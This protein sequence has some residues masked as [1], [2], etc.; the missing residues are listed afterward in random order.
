MYTSSM[1]KASDPQQELWRREAPRLLSDAD[2]ARIFGVTPG[3]IPKLR[4][5]GWLPRR[6]KV[7]SGKAGGKGVQ[8][9]SFLDAVAAEVARISSAEF[10]I[11]PRDLRRMVSVITGGDED[12]V[13]AS[14]VIAIKRDDVPGSI[15]MAFFAPEEVIKHEAVLADWRKQ[16]KMLDERSLIE[17]VE[18]VANVLYEKMGKAGFEF[19]GVAAPSKKTKTRRRRS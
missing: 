6:K 13:R 17:I 11:P 1:Q 10:R 18:H 14:K 19:S 5:K 3:Y 4:S 9:Y 2:V 16:E 12:A 15:S 7:G 8:R